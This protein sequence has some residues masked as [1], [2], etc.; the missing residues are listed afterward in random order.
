MR[1]MDTAQAAVVFIT[2]HWQQ[3]HLSF[4]EA[5]FQLSSP[6]LPHTPLVSSSLSPPHVLACPGC[7][8]IH[9]A[10]C[11]KTGQTILLGLKS[12]D[13]C[14]VS[15]ELAEDDFT[16]ISWGRPESFF[17]STNERRNNQRTSLSHH[18]AFLEQRY[19]TLP[20]V[21]ACHDIIK[22]KLELQTSPQTEYINVFLI[23]HI[24][25]F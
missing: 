2:S 10:N 13:L 5:S 25:G 24:S 22:Q 7:A 21:K 23:K 17:Y 3:N 20:A 18:W 11:W 16:I 6:I 15:G 8:W 1:K 19:M 14:F 12:Q 9:R 4:W